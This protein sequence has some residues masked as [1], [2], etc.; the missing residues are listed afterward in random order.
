MRGLFRRS[1]VKVQLSVG[2]RV[3]QR[4]LRC[5]GC[6]R[7]Q[8]E[9]SARNNVPCGPFTFLVRFSSCLVGQVESERPIARN[10]IDHTDT[11]LE[12]HFTFCF[13]FSTRHEFC[14]ALVKFTLG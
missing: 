10:A 11:T 9:Q 7:G 8:E 6:S 12:K 1:Q 14:H 3:R 13:S 5:V 4:Q 2:E